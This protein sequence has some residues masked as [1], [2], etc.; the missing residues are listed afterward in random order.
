[1][2]T[3]KL[4]RND[5]DTVI[6]DGCNPELVEGARF[7]GVLEIPVIEASDVIKVPSGL[8]PFSKRDRVDVRSFAVCEYELDRDF[9]DL[10]RN[11]EPY[12]KEL[13]P[14]DDV[15]GEYWKHADF[16]RYPDWTSYQRKDEE[17]AH[18]EEAVRKPGREG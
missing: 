7:D 15:F 10:L 12:V 6:T 13:R 17:Q 5:K 14:P 11:P 4:K 3:R 2:A 16:V 18:P 1:M 9:A 8:V